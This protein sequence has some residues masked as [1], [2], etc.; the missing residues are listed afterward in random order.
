MDL[1]EIQA[2]VQPNICLNFIVTIDRIIYARAFTVLPGSVSTRLR[3][4]D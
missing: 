4:A 3:R 2:D 1:N